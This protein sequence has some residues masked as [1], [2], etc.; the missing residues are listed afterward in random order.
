MAKK[1]DIAKTKRLLLKRANT[2]RAG[3]KMKK[4]TRVHYRCEQ[5]GRIR[6]YMR[7]FGLCRICFRV[8]ALKGELAGVTKSS[9]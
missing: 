5:C 6:S 2:F 8:K 4:G 7:K 3:V 1:S 9:W